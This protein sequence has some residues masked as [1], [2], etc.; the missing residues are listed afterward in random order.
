MARRFVSVDSESRERP[1]PGP[2]LLNPDGSDNIVRVG[3]TDDRLHDLYHALLITSWPRLIL[4][5]SLFYVAGNAI[6][7]EAYLAAGDAIAGAR[8]GSFTDAFFFSV[9]TMGTVGYGVFAPKTFAAHVLVT[10]E[11]FFG[12]LGFAMVTGL[13]FAKFSRP[14]ARVLFSRVATVSTRDGVPSLSIRLAN[15]RRTQIVEA[16]VRVILGRDETTPEGEFIRRFYDLELVRNRNPMFALTWTVT[17]P[18]T[19]KSP[20]YDV[21]TGAL[22]AA[23]SEL[24]VSVVGIDETFV[25]TVHA[26]HAYSTDDIVWG[27][28]FADLISHLPD[29]RR[30][31]DYTRFH[32]VVRDA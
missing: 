13:V 3:V 1:H 27:G 12:L 22:A 2:R 6:F 11:V 31:I 14:T 18:L 19:S 17:H 30:Q 26:R 20:L 21:T 8:P 7:A 25:Q 16:Q 32:D 9:Q 24:V 10:V 28:R 4:L 29:G 5:F 23:R 15:A